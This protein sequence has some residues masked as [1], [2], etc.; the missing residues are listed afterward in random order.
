MYRNDNRS[1]SLLIAALL[2]MPAA[3][4]ES[5]ES[6][7][8]RHH[9][10]TDIVTETFGYDDTTPSDYRWEDIFQGCARRDCIPSIDEPR[11]I[12]ALEATFLEDDDLVLAVD[13]RG[14]ARAYPTRILVFHEI[15]NDTVAGEPIAISYC[16]LCGS[17]LAFRRVLDGKVLEFGVSGLL[18]NSDLIMY[19]RH[20]KSLWQQIEGAAFAGPLRGRKLEDFPMTMTTWREWRDAHPVG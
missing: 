10:P 7:P 14:E 6:E 19:D 15:V 18:H 12:S 1:A 20:T 2:T 3:A 16:P 9:W 8:R 17:G 11:F 5:E 13:Y 4:A